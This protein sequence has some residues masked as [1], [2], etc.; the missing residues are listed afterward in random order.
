M[1]NSTGFCILRVAFN[2]VVCQLGMTPSATNKKKCVIILICERAQRSIQFNAMFPLMKMKPVMEWVIATANFH[3]KWTS[4]PRYMTG[5]ELCSD[6][7]HTISHQ[8]SYRR[9]RCRHGDTQLVSPSSVGLSA[10]WTSSNVMPPTENG[11]VVRHRKKL[12]CV[13]FLFS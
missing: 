3:T 13:P 6:F 9:Q 12:I 4:H 7:R 1:R 11:K 2:S 10:V 8:I 5:T